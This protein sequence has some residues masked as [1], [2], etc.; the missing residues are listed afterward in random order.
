MASSNGK[1]NGKQRRKKREED[2][3]G[4]LGLDWPLPEDEAAA[5]ENHDAPGCKDGG[6][7]GGETA[8]NSPDRPD[9]YPCGGELGPEVTTAGERSGDDMPPVLSERDTRDEMHR[10]LIS[11]NEWDALDALHEQLDQVEQTLRRV[12]RTLQALTEAKTAAL[13]GRT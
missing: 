10:L 5:V 2:R 8:P 11:Q 1:S 12:Q 3:Y 4:V 9:R 7:L 6:E 13:P